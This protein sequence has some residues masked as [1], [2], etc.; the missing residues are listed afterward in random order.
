M[1]LIFKKSFQKQYRRLDKRDQKR[2]L[3]ALEIFK[4]DPND[5]RLRNHML[6][7]SMQGK[8]S[9]SAGFDLRVLFREVGGYVEVIL[10][11]VGSHNRVY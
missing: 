1:K 2:V 4:I 8:R 7:G 11:D 6:V 5:P 10:L 9:F 3:D